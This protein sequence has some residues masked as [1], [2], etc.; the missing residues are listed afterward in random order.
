LPI[1]QPISTGRRRRRSSHTP[2]NSDKR[3]TGTNRSAFSTPTSNTVAFSV[4]IATSG[5]ANWV[6]SVPISETDSP[7]HSL[8]KSRLPKTPPLAPAAGS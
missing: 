7:A 1:A 5:I 3:I 6:T 4:R 2:A 8:T